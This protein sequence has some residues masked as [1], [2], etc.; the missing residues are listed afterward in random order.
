MTDR[1]ND[2]EASLASTQATLASLNNRIQEVE[3]A[4]LEY[5][6]RLSLVEQKCT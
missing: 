2:L 3:N 4:S 5:D 1:F 6:R